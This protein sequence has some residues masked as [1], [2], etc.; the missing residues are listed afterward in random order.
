[1]QRESV[2]APPSRAMYMCVP[3]PSALTPHSRIRLRPCRELIS[4]YPHDGEAALVAVNTNRRSASS[5]TRTACP[6][7]N[8]RCWDALYGAALSSTCPHP[9]LPIVGLKV[10]ER[11]A[12]TC[13]T[14]AW[15][16]EDG[17]E[18]ATSGARGNRKLWRLTRMSTC[19]PSVGPS[20][21]AA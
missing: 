11:E 20:V 10:P 13:E 8:D 6:E 5:M 1:M 14:A 16:R 2:R 21:A 19:V 9:E 18:H 3:S 15:P 4:P 7:A 12:W 17:D